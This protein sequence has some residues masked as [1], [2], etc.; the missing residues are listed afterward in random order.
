MATGTSLPMHR[1]ERTPVLLLGGVSLVR[2]LGLAGIPVVVASHDMGEPAFGSRYCVGRC[3]LPPPDR[4]DALIEAIVRIGDRLSAQY[5]RRVPLMYGNDDYLELIH[6]HRERLE[7]YFLMLLNDADVAAALLVKDRFQAFA[8]TRGL[9]VPR[10]LDWDTLATV[11]GPVLAKPSNKVDWHESLLRRALFDRG[12]ALVFPSGAHAARDADV[13]RFRDQL[14]FQ[15]YVPGGDTCNFSFHGFADG[16]GKVIDSFVGRKIRTCPPVTGE[17]AFIELDRDRELHELGTRIAAQVPLK[18]V[19]KMDFKKDERTGRWYLLEVNARF[20]LWHYLGACNGV[21]LL[22]TAYDYLMEGT[23]PAIEGDYDTRYR[24]LSLELDARAF[25]ELHARGELGLF[26]WL[27]SIVFS[28]NV[29]NVFSWRDP[30]P[31][32]RFWAW[33]FVRR[34]DRGAERLLSMV[35]RCRST[36]S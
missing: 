32:L 17:S 13:A 24:W 30:G 9:P 8:E 28:R 21:N 36:A 20:N 5:G 29:Y 16:E 7:R 35:R 3:L 25:R 22:R 2:S 26:A 14:T 31:W 11:E 10:S 27:A 12:K 18:G 19:F 15:E 33:R 4:A 1:L 34:F 6:A 23:R